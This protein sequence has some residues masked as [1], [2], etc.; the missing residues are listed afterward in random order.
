MRDRASSVDPEARA[1][2]VGAA[3]N[4]EFDYAVVATGAVTNF[5]GN[6]DATKNAHRLRSLS[7]TTDLV[8]GLENPGVKRVVVVGGGYTGVEAATHLRRFAAKSGRELEIVVLELQPTVLAMRPTWMQEYV[9]RQ[10]EELDIEVR[11]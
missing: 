7:Q 8:A 5:Y 10:L 11:T 4:V 3:R 1:V 2:T 9:E 6:Q